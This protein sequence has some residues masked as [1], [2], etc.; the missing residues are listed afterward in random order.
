MGKWGTNVGRLVLVLSLSGLFIGCTPA[1]NCPPCAACAEPEAQLPAKT[2]R[3]A[4]TNKTKAQLDSHFKSKGW[5]YWHFSCVGNTLHASYLA[6][7]LFDV[8]AVLRGDIEYL[9]DLY[10]GDIYVLRHYE[11]E[12][13]GV[14]GSVGGEIHCDP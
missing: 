4:C 11:G 9:Q 10:P 1:P 3:T 2:E 13:L 8:Q 5:R 12:T 7:A 14:C 6:G